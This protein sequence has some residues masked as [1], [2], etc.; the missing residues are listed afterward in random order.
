MTL[1]T[2]SYFLIL[3]FNINLKNLKKEILLNPNWILNNWYYSL[4]S[5][6]RAFLDTLYLFWEIHFDNTSKLD[7]EEILRLLPI[8]KNKTLEK[9]AK[10]YFVK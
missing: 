7:Y 1:N 4:A 5:P 6:E 9:R 10:S 3:D 8:Y 2:E